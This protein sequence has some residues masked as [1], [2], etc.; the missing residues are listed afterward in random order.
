[1]SK[2]TTVYRQR[3]IL[4][5]DLNNKIHLDK[6]WLQPSPKSK[7]WFESNED[8]LESNL[9]HKPNP[10]K[11]SYYGKMV[12]TLPRKLKDS[13]YYLIQPG[14]V[15]KGKDCINTPDEFYFSDVSTKQIYHVTSNPHRITLVNL[16]LLN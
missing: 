6:D 10:V 7:D 8:W 5:R 3:F 12:E 15:F 16:F 11:I 13:K 4:F 2:S 9:K 1:M 14:L